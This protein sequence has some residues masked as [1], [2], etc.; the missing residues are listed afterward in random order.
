MTLKAEIP[1]SQLI[2]RSDDN[3]I[4]R[5]ETEDGRR[6]LAS[7]PSTMGGKIVAGAVFFDFGIA[8]AITDKHREY[9]ASFV[10]PVKK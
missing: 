7:V 1:S 2:R 4:L 8:D 10:M 5:G 9:P 3:L 6:G